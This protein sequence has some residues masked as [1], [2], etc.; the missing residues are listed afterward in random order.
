MADE[1]TVL[2]IVSPVASAA[3]MMAV[4]SIDPTTIRAL[5]AG[6]RRMLRMPK[7]RKMRLRRAR[8]ARATSAAPRAAAR[9]TASVSIGMPKSLVIRPASCRERRRRVGYENLIALTSGRSPED[10]HELLHLLEVEAPTAR[11]PGLRVLLGRPEGDHESFP[12]RRDED[13]GALVTLLLVQGGQHG[14]AKDPGRLFDAHAQRVDLGRGRAS[15]H[16]CLLSRSSSPTIRPSIIRTIR[17]VERP[18]AMS[19]VT[20][21]NVRP[22]SSFSCRMRATISPAFSLSRSPVGSSAQTSAGSLTSA[23]A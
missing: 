4:P 13:I 1:R 14:L 18:T 3:A 2:L 8:T 9:T 17:C 22:R 5:R 23:R 10:G 7:R 11:E 12:L 6:R 20:I 16:G 15:N 21:R 19:W